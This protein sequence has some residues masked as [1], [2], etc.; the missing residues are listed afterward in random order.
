MQALDFFGNTVLYGTQ[1]SI[2]REN[3]LNPNV[4]VH[5]VQFIGI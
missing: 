4:P 1:S 5:Q 2:Q 3:H